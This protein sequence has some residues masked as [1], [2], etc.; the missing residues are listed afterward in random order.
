MNLAAMEAPTV[1]PGQKEDKAENRIVYLIAN[2]R[3]SM[4]E[5]LRMIGNRGDFKVMH[6]PANWAYCHAHNY[7]KLT[8]GWYREDA[9]KTYL[10]AKDDIY[11]EAENSAVF[12]G[13]NTHTAKDFLE[14][15][16]E[17]IKDPRVQLIIL[18]RNPHGSII[19]Y[20][21][22]KE[23][24]FDEL[25]RSQ[26]SASMGF[27]DVYEL[28]QV[29]NSQGCNPLIIQTED[30]YNNTKNTVQSVCDY[31]NVPCKE[32]WL[33]WKDISENFTSFPG[34][35]TIEVTKTAVDWHMDAIKSTGFTRSMTYV[36]DEEGNPTF[37]EISNPK[38]REICIEAYQENLPYYELLQTKA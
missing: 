33:H 24:I 10:Q 16:K 4:V 27:K 12:V 3:A 8:E 28:V 19:D 35:Y 38:H 34:W 26:L 5:F 17:F 37:Q 36:V 22:K 20:Y 21:E 1:N 9:P 30:L 15:N 31:L 2:P 32:E 7:T 23:K 13:E 6:I 14:E 25:P 29:M 11:K 18:V